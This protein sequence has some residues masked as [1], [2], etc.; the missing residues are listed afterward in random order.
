MRKLDIATNIYLGKWPTKQGW[1][2]RWFVDVKTMNTRS[3]QILQKLKMTPIQSNSRL[4][5]F[6][7]GVSN[8]SLLVV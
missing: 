2:K 4:K 3:W 5:G 8:R 7:E 6:P 1:L